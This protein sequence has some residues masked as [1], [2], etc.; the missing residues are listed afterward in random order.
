MTI[1]NIFESLQHLPV[2]YRGAPFWSW[3]GF[4]EENELRLQIRQMKAA[5][6][7]GFFMHSRIGLKTPYLQKE[8]F[9]KINV[10]ID[11]AQKNGM[12]AYIYDEDRWP[13]GSAGGLA[14][15]E[16]KYRQQFLRAAEFDSVS[17]CKKNPGVLAYFTAVKK[18]R[19]LYDLHYHKTIPAE[20][21]QGS[22][23]IR[24]SHETAI[25]STWYNNSTY[26]NTLDPEAVQNF[27]NI[28]VFGMMQRSP[29][30]I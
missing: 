23:L 25:P 24:I 14:T 13:S 8:W 27:I 26:L 30:S 5:G 6:L 16:E 20:L 21:E 2:I 10:C 18:G 4:L 15:K 7:G 22:I 9:E 1:D 29:I 17:D 12:Y 28:I 11:E 3:N 19:K